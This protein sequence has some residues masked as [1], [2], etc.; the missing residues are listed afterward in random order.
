MRPYASQAPSL[1][2]ED[3]SL[4]SLVAA[5]AAS[6]P[7]LITPW[8]LTVGDGADDRRLDAASRKAELFG[9]QP[10]V[11]AQPICDG[12][13]QASRLLLAACEAAASRGLAKVVWP[14]AFGL[15][16]DSLADAID[17]ARLIS[18]VSLV[19]GGPTAPTVEIPLADLTDA[20]LV[21]AAID[22]A[23]PLSGDFW[24]AT[25]GDEE[26]WSAALAS[27]GEPLRRPRLAA[28]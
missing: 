20:Q 12:P 9:C 27:A 17:L 1:L 4:A 28:G 6:S 22:L 25:P 26:R 8:V 7:H 24:L 16:V 5:A 13:Y 21:E 11:S 2:I 15:D 10:P 18:H 3:A 14:A 19:Q 23:A